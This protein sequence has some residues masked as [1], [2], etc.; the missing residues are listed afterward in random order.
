MGESAK[1]KRGDLFR[2]ILFPSLD[3]SI[4]RVAKN[5]S[6]A[7]IFVYDN[8]TRIS[9]NERHP[10]PLPADW[11]QVDQPKPRRGATADLVV[12]DEAKRLAGESD[13]SRQ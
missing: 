8:R 1:P 7:D 9:W 2:T 5:G 3:I 13:D 4:T 11:K 10:L 6:W 12:F